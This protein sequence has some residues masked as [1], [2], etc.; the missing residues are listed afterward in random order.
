MRAHRARATVVVAAVLAVL[1]GLL[2]AAP[3]PAVAGDPGA[4]SLITEIAGRRADARLDRQQCALLGRAWTG[5]AC[6]R[7]RCQR[8][9]DRMRPRVD[10]EVCLYRGRAARPYGFE[11]D[12]RLCRQ[13]HRRWVATVNLCASDPRRQLGV[14]A[15]SPLCRA[16]NTT[17]VMHREVEGYWDECLHPARVAALASLASAQGDRFQTVAAQRSRVLCATRPG[18]D[19]ANGVCGPRQGGVPPA[20]RGGVLL[21]GDSVGW[22]SQNELAAK[23]PGWSLDS[24]PG[25]TIGELDARVD[26][27][28]TDHLWPDTL[29]VALGANPAAGYDGSDLVG[30]LAGLPARTRVVLVVPHRRPGTASPSTVRKVRSYARTMRRLDRTRPGTCLA[31]WQRKA[32]RNRGLLVDGVHPTTPGQKVWAAL[33]K[34]SA[35]R[36]S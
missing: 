33:V 6:S 27:Y 22:R 34:R 2:A 11:V 16:P 31:D 30:Y 8:G 1:A 29:V 13:L 17:Y 4:G 26:R 18:Q 35:A 12:A 24:V 36:C 20:A 7:H 3:S 21:V 14:V 32:S 23:R 15:R 25:R 28:R 10:A 5:S 9:A 19:F